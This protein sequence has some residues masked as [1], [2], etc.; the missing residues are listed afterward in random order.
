MFYY[1]RKLIILQDRSFSPH[2]KS[3]AQ[4]YLRLIWWYLSQTWKWYTGS[5]HPKSTSGFREIAHTADWELEVWAPNLLLL[6]EQA[7]LGMYELTAAQISSEP[8]ISRHITLQYI[9]PETLLIDFLNE[10]LYLAESERLIFD[11][12]E[13]QVDADE[14]HASLLG[15]SIVS[16]DKEIKAATY[17]NLEIAQTNQGLLANIVFDV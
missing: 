5:M 10:L 9:E 8:R 16:M 2:L 7:A 14:L 15:A 12:F 3:Y 11:N 17:H 1:R 13:L 4:S 6:L